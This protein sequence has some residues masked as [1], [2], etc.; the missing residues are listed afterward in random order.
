MVAPSVKRQD[1]L[2]AEEQ[3][4]PLFWVIFPLVFSVNFPPVLCHFST[5]LIKPK[6]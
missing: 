4:M 3:K 2:A 5:L 1:L 6:S